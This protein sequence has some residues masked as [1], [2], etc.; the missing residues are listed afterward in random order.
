MINHRV[1]QTGCNRLGTVAKGGILLAVMVFISFSPGSILS[2]FGKE[3]LSIS[4]ITEP[5]GNV[6][7]SAI[8]V[9]TISTIF[10]KE[11]TFVKKGAVIL[12]LDKQVEELEAERRKLIWESKAE[13]KAAAV[14]VST[15]KSLLGST[16][17]LFKSTGSV[18]RE[19]LE[20]MELEYEIAEAEKERLETAEERER[21]EYEMA[22]EALQKRS[23]VSPI[24][25][26]VIKLF[27]KE[28]ES[29]QENKPL[30]QVVDTSSGIFVNNVEEWV[31]RTLRTGQ[32]VD[33]KIRTGNESIAKKGTIIF[34]SPVVDSASGLLE[35]KTEFD[36]SDG[37]VR[38]GIS[39]SMILRDR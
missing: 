27:L 23:L 3:P 16:R 38:P 18:S 29:C 20:K 2:S 9:G 32:S 19:E 17:E 35:V 39:G 11:G 14:R 22:R 34:V 26:T 5:I 8:A 21:I 4:G 37:S 12:E 10:V 13:V 24:Q 15:L 1:T 7:L 33:L 31:G 6:T 30:A 25:G 28:G 36:N